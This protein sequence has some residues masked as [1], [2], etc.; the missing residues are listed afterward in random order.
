MNEVKKSSVACK[1]K[2]PEVIEKAMFRAN[3]SGVAEN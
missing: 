3:V 2:V 1:K